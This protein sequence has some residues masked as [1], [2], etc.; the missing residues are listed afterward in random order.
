[1]VYKDYQTGPDGLPAGFAAELIRVA[2]AFKS[3][4]NIEKGSRM[5][6]AKSA[7]GLLSL[8]ASPNTVIT[9]TAEGSDENEALAAVARLFENE[10]SLKEKG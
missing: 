6:N 2:G 7:M 8:G 1:M 3:L 5:L 9:V 4:I 10:F